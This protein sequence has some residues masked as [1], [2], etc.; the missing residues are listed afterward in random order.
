MRVSYWY[1]IIIAEKESM[2]S[3][4]GLLPSGTLNPVQTLLADLQSTSKV[5]IW[6]LIAWIVAFACALNEDIVADMIAQKAPPT[7]LWR[8][9]FIETFQYGDPL[10]P[11]NGT[12]IYDPVIPANRIIKFHK[13]TQNSNGEV[14]IKVGKD[15]GS[16]FPDKLTAPELAAFTAWVIGTGT[17]GTTYTIISD[18]ADIFKIGYTIFYNP[19]VL[20]A[21][22]SLISDPTIFPVNDVINQYLQYNSV[23]D[24]AG[25]FK[26]EILDTLVNA[27]TGVS[28][29]NPTLKQAKYGLFSYVDILGAAPFTYLPNSGYGIISTSPGETLA[30]T[31][32]YVVDPAY[33]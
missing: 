32:T 10:V 15:N 3:L 28:L 8:D 4:T 2:S 25:L 26:S 24:F 20:N 14:V 19:Q 23:N 7:L 16:G 21:D 22:G 17:E 18:D 33:Q 1:N 9:N 30:D 12:F 29:A 13:T 11:F 5:A 27:A 31:I 6:R